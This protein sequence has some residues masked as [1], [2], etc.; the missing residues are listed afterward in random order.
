MTPFFSIVV[1]VYNVE[2][3]LR[4]CVDSILAQSFTDF[5]LILV[6]DGSPDSCGAICDGYAAADAR[7]RTSH[8]ANTGLAGA[9]R[10]GLEA[11]RAEYVGFVDSDDWVEP[12]WLATVRDG[13][14][15][16]NSPD[17]VLFDHRR[18]TSMP[19]VPLFLQPGYYDKARLEREVY[20]YM[21]WDARRR[22]FGTQLLPAY[23][24]LRIARRQLL[25]DHYIDRDVK[26][27][28]FE[29]MAMA[30]EC[31]YHADSL[32]FC[33]E[34]LYVYRVRESSL[35][36]AYRPDFFRE[37]QLCFGYM[38]SRLGGRDPA[39]D[40]Q[41]NGAYLR[42][43]LVGMA[44]DVRQWGPQAHAHTARAM[45]ETGIAGELSFGGLPWD[46]K[47]FLLLLKCRMYR[48]ALLAVRV[49]S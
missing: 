30:Y 15:R 44:N 6:D 5:E 19:P 16:G 11:A 23:I 40:R 13:L 31:L 12:A 4:Q 35:L 7:V 9:R 46:M 47:L 17:I 38:R 14:E 1:P 34:R 3:F 39:L 22:P 20:P 33:P 21:L 8:Q 42:K 45:E 24:P 32:W 26:L 28:L 37:I 36:H 2:P 18:D 29:D 43:V 48:L 41:L 27:P 10:T 49:R 25:L